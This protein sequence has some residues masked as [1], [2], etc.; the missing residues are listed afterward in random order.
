MFNFRWLAPYNSQFLYFGIEDTNVLSNTG[1]MFLIFLIMVAS[2]LLWTILICLARRNYR[3]PNWRKMGVYA[4]KNRA[5]KI[6]SIHMIVEGYTDLI[7]A[8]ALNAFVISRSFVSWPLFV[9]TWLNNYSNVTLV[10]VTLVLSLIVLILP[11]WIRYQLLKNFKN[12]K[13]KDV[14]EELGT[15]YAEYKVNTRTSAIFTFYSMIRKMALV[16]IL[17][18]LDQ[19]PWLQ[20]MLIMSG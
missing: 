4:S 16:Y 17:I 1:S 6:P 11:F 13:D 10:V 2:Y 14:K 15:Y 20:A 12:L 5:F 3:K 18:V 19:L 8:I 9:S 7:L